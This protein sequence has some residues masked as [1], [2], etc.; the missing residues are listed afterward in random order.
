MILKIV[1][2]L[3]LV[4]FIVSYTWKLT[5]SLQQQEP[6]SQPSAIDLAYYLA[7]YFY[8]LCPCD[9]EIDQYHRMCLSEKLHQGEGHLCRTTV[10]PIRDAG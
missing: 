2:L 3:M 6:F 4:M 7:I 8:W 10:Q 5:S 1:G 9:S